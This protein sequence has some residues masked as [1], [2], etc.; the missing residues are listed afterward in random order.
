M[1]VRQAIM[2]LDK[3]IR[4]NASGSEE[5][6]STSEEISAQALQLRSAISFF[7]INETRPALAER[8]GA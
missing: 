7:K 5:I 6:A 8:A 1:L 4:Q 2:D 3:V